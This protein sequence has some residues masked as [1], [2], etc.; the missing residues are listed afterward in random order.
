MHGQC[1]Q[2]A[3]V[4]MLSARNMTAFE[5]VPDIKKKKKSLGNVLEFDLCNS[6]ILTVYIVRICQRTAIAM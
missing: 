6:F 5:N 1:V 3:D 4:R 2:I